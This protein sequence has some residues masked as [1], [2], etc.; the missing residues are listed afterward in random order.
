M[1]RTRLLKSQINGKASLKNSKNGEG[2]HELKNYQANTICAIITEDSKE[3]FC[4]AKVSF[5]F[6]RIIFIA[7]AS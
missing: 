2:S 1:S 4:F 7:V 3:K 5:N 6:H